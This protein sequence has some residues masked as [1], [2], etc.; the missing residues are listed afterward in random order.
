MS[1]TSLLDVWLDGCD[2]SLIQ[3]TLA[4]GLLLVKCATA[5]LAGD[6]HEALFEKEIRLSL[7]GVR[8]YE[9]LFEH[10]RGVSRISYGTVDG[11]ELA[12]QKRRQRKGLDPN[13]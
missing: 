2:R 3:V 9:I 13:L 4:D 5:S 1:I 8:Y 12:I 6:L 7:A 10:R 11:L